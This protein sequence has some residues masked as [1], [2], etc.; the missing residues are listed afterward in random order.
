MNPRRA[1]FA[2]LLGLSLPSAAADFADAANSGALASSF[3]L[4]PL[5]QGP[6]LPAGRGRTTF[7]FDLTN[8]FV[9][10][11]DCAAECI[12][13]DGETAR[14]AYGER[15]GL[16]GGWEF[17][18][19]VPL[20]DQGG[21]FLDS[22]IE[23][24]HSWFGLPNGGRE[25]AAQDRYGYQY[26]RG[27]VTRFAVTEPDEG[28]GDVEL[29]LGRAIGR[30]VA[31]RAMLKLPTGEERSL[32]GGNRGMALWLDAALPLPAPWAGYV[33]AGVSHN[34]I[35][36][37]LP[38]EQNRTIPF[39]GLG[40][41]LA[42]AR[43]ARLTAQLYAHGRLYDGSALAPLARPAVPASL[44]LQFDLSRAARLEVGFLED[45]SVGAS[46]DFTGYLVLGFAGR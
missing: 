7:A 18:V 13:L 44:G 12:V 28:L 3:A 33:A 19:E 23:D 26:V 46:P 5:G 21:G 22:W 34:D 36:A 30:S 37:R 39:G 1:L 27:G 38:R 35:G 31:M 43:R 6:V 45:A 41:Q 2:L 32:R 29:T 8:E 40:L 42:L 17:G 24:W 10:V 20:L 11:G 14:L 16:G 25:Q 4:P 9:A 15:R